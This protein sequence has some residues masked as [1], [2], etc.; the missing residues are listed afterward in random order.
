M[1]NTILSEK[2]TQLIEKA[3]LR[4]GWI[5]DMQA[6]LAIFKE[7]YTTASAYKRINLLSKAGWLKRIKK[8]LYLVID[9]ITARS[10]ISISL[11]SVAN[12]LMKESYV[13]FAHA[14]NY[15][16]MFDQYASTI[17]SITDKE[18]KKYRN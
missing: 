9:S 7:E 11:L 2:D 5:L 4:G 17:V 18:N 1:K 12:I 6:L 16:N 15:Y 13:S 10:Q 14:L 3:I 8:G